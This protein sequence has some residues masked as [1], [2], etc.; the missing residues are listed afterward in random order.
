MF[1]LVF[2]YNA[3]PQYASFLIICTVVGYTG[4]WVAQRVERSEE[5]KRRPEVQAHLEELA[6]ARQQEI[7]ATRTFYASPEWRILREQVITEQGRR[8]RQCK[9]LITDDFELTVDHIKPRSKFPELALDKSNL[10]VLCRQCNSSKGD[11]IV[12]DTVEEPELDAPAR[13]N[14]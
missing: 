13:A 14:C 3:H 9:R 12:G 5:A 8:C 1:I 10:R 6:R 11:A 2:T 4:A 7:E